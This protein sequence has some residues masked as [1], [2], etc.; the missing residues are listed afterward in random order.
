MSTSPTRGRRRITPNSFTGPFTLG[1][2]QNW[3]VSQQK[4][5]NPEGHVNRNSTS[6]PSFHVG[7]YTRDELHD[8]PPYLSGGPFDTIRIHSC[9]P[10]LGV[11]G[12]GAYYRADKLRRYIGG[13]AI[14]DN[15]DWMG[16]MSMNSVGTYLDGNS[17]NYPSM[18]DWGDKAYNGSKPKLEKAGAGVFFAELRDLPRM[19]KTSANFFHDAWRGLTGVSTLTKT[20]T[21]KKAADHF[22]NHQFGW[23][24]FIQDLKRFYNA[25]DQADRHIKRLTDENGQWIRRRITLKD[26]TQSSV[27]GTGSGLK[28]FPNTSFSSP[29]GSPWLVGSPTWQVREELTTRIYAVGKYR[30]YRPE[31]DRTDPDHSSA[32]NDMKRQ[33]TLYGLRISP[34]NVYKATPWTWAIDWV[35]NFGDQVDK[36]NDMLVDSIAA[37][38][39]FVMQAQIRT[40]VFTQYIPFVSGPVTLQFTRVIETKQRREGLSPFGFSLSLANLTPRQLAI[41]GA[42]GVSRGY[43]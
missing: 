29:F 17:V 25:F 37:K 20:M 5:S 28:L 6:Y 24:P 30:Y 1:Y 21:P 41:A 26:E 8:G 43:L 42:L 14:P 32:I 38:Y 4:W 10:P 31:F 2:Y 16:G 27:V 33:A 22:L 3:S 23:N 7:Q 11:Y 15:D 19:L 12:V 18:A 35:S 36:A 39:L 34:S 13:F 40:R 9:D